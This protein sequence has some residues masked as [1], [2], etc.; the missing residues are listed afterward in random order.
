MSSSFKA[1][2]RKRAG[3]DGN[4]NDSHSASDKRSFSLNKQKVL[5]LSSRGVTERYRH[6]MSDLQSLLPHTKKG[7]Y[8]HIYIYMLFLHTTFRF[9]SIG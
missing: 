5:L 9:K 3:A 2:S 8:I 1:I 7:I 4:D 6:L